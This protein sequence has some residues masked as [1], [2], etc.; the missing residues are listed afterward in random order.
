M[1]V[2]PK[3]TEELG[4]R[5]RI[6]RQ[7]ELVDLVSEGV[8]IVQ[9]ATEIADWEMTLQLDSHELD[10]IEFSQDTTDRE[11]GGSPGR[12]LN[13]GQLRRRLWW[14]TPKRIENS[15]SSTWPL[16]RRSHSR[17]KSSQVRL[18]IQPIMDV[19]CGR[20]T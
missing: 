4:L 9:S 11:L 14:L 8:I 19:S 3:F 2:E 5:P 10:H 12:I 15:G 6:E 17:V 18:T 20:R 16:V 13:A 7:Y 1:D